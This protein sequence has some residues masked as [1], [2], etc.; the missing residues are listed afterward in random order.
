MYVLPVHFP[1]HSHLHFRHARLLGLHLLGLIGL[2]RGGPEAEESFSKLHFVLE[3][4]E[5]NSNTKRKFQL[6]IVIGNS[7]EQ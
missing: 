3:L 4:T 1:T 6:L 7:L 2:F 5:I